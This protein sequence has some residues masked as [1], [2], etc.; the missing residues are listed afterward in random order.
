MQD[1]GVLAA[2][3]GVASASSRIRLASTTRDP[4]AGSPVLVSHNAQAVTLTNASAASACTSM[5]SG[6]AS[7]SFAIASA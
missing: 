3:S 6:Y 4:G 1:A 7:A 2:G 5:S